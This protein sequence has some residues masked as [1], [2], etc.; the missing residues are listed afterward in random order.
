MRMSVP[1]MLLLLPT[2]TLADE[3]MWTAPGWPPCA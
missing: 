1:L 3:G 2:A